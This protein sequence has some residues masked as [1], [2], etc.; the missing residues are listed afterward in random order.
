M[1][2]QK[3]RVVFPPKQIGKLFKSGDKKGRKR[4]K[5]KEKEKWIQ[6]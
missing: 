5:K 3:D 2:F 6:K 1:V 4:G